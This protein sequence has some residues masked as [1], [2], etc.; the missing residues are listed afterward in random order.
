MYT[1]ITNDELSDMGILTFNDNGFSETTLAYK[2]LT[3]SLII[4]A[5]IFSKNKYIGYICCGEHQKPKKEHFEWYLYSGC[6]L[7]KPNLMYRN[8]IRLDIS[9]FRTFEELYKYYEI[10]FLKEIYLKT[11]KINRTYKNIDLYIRKFN[12]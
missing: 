4:N 12:L 8:P 7:H 5:F 2:P 3:D 9:N 6:G 11:R 1:Y 10:I